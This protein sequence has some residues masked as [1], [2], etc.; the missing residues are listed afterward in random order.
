M[1]LIYKKIGSISII[2][3][4]YELNGKEITKNAIAHCIFQIEEICKREKLNYIVSYWQD[5][6]KEGSYKYLYFYFLFAIYLRVS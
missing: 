6:Y 4:Y 1:N 3:I 5:N 2:I